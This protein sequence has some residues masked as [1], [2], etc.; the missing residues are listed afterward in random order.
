MHASGEMGSVPRTWQFIID[1]YSIKRSIKQF[2][3]FELSKDKAFVSFAP[4]I[5]VRG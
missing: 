1:F 5:T 4:L 3:L 2:W